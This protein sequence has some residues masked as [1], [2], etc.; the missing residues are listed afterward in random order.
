MP[1]ANKDK[2]KI[3]S[4]NLFPVVGIGASAGGLDAFKRL[5]KAI[6]ESSGMAYIL[7][8]HLDPTH[9]S[10]LAEIL[11]RVT[12]IPVQEITDNIK[13][14]PD[15]IYII[16]SNKSLTATDGVLQ[17]SARPPKGDKNMPIDIFFTSL[18]EVHQNHS[19]GI[20]LSGT[21]SDGTLGL[22]A[23]KEKGGITFAQDVPS[24]S[25]DGMPQSAIDAGVVDFILAPEKIPEQLIALIK[26]HKII[27]E[28]GKGFAE[29]MEEEGFKQII[30]LIRMRKAVDFT[31][32]KQTTIRRR[33]SRRIALTMKAGITD[34]LAF[35]KENKGEQ[36][37]LFQDLLIPVTEFFRDEKVFEKICET[38]FPALLKERP[39][40][41]PIR[42]WVAGCSSGE[43]AY[44]IAMCLHE[45]LGNKA[46]TSNVQIFATD[47]SDAAIIKARTGS[48]SKNEIGGLSDARL[49]QF[50]TKTDGKFHINKIIRDSCVFATHNYLKD[51]PFA[52]LFLLLHL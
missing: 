8:Q 33:I 26:T 51:P 20:V 43:E 31:Y 6:P 40:N 38:I 11:Q 24:A 47:I 48:Y 34:Y 5:L 28:N 32:Y 41:E 15:H 18:A 9:E 49:K 39:E 16:P 29:Q 21:A 10:I 25:Y 45:F 37:V 1:K 22:Q 12:K 27:P 30:T 44:S 19:I 17:L 13:V 3:L 23:I 14:A 42:V 35:L 4:A 46:T 52:G 2:I 7:V 36:D 50:F